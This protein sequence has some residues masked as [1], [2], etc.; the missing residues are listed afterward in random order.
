MNSFQGQSQDDFSKSCIFPIEEIYQ[1]LWEKYNF[2]KKK[3]GYTRRKLFL[4]SVSK[5]EKMEFYITLG[6][7][8]SVKKQVTDYE[9]YR[10]GKIYSKGFQNTPNF[11]L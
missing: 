11:C 6:S 8:F 3:I 4:F 5:T 10:N 7:N 1:I 9:V 2:Y